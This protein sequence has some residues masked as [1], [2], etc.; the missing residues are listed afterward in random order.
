MTER[1]TVKFKVA[2]ES[3][4]ADEVNVAVCD[5][6]PTN[7]KPF[8]EYGSKSSHIVIAVVLVT[9]GFTVKFKVA[10]ESQPAAEVN[11]A[12]C[13]PAPA[14]VKPFHEYGSKSSH[15]VIAVVLVTSGFTVK[16]KV[17][18]ESQ[19]AAEVSVAV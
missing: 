16:F 8:H 7:V 15:I 11:V 17:A 6:A 5:P 2:N 13:D 12:V 4:P 1:F 10:N 18:N 19:P 3:Q 14:N 9:S